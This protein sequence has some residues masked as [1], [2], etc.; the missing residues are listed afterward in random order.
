MKKLSN[1]AFIAIVGFLV[2]NFFIKNKAEADAKLSYDNFLAGKALFIDVR[3]ESEVKDGMIKGALWFPL[4]KIEEN[5][6]AEILRIQEATKDKEIFVYCK[7]GNRANTVK[8]YLEE[9]GIKS[10]NMGGFSAL[11]KDGLPTQSGPK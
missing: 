4:S 3:E 8:A 2:F 5:Q 10:L 7:S 1:Y 11:V 6:K 9:A